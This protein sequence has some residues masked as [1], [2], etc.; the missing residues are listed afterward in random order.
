MSILAECPFCHKKQSVRNKICSCG[1]KLDRL[2]KQREKVKYWIQYYLGNKQY[3]ES[4][5]YSLEEAKDAEGKRRSQKREGRIFDIKQDTVLTFRDL[6][7]WYLELENTKSLASYR[8]I[9]IR[10]SKFNARFGNTLLNE[11]KKTDLE[12]FQTSLKREDL[13][14]SYIDNIVTQAHV[15]VK[16]AYSNDIISHDALKPFIITKRILKK[17]SN[18]RNRILTYKEFKD[19]AQDAPDHLKGIIVMGYYT[20]M[21]KGEILGLT[22]NRV[23]LEKREIRLEAIDTKTGDPRTCPIGKELLSILQALPSRLKSPYVFIYNGDPIKNIKKSLQTACERAKIPYGRKKKNG[24]TFH[25]I[26]HTFNTCARKAG[27]AEP[28]IMA[29]TGHETREM[30]DRYNKIDSQDI[31]QAMNRIE[32]FLENSV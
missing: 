4:I 28:V 32:N 21:R 5:G 18:A 27:I 23:D 14:Y 3:R 12:G 31:R 19:L 26:R 9:G 22:W 8:G 24:I 6:A 16:T 10:L 7:E 30:F 15:M 25:D 11:L 13:S 1:A 20:G 2:K 29:I 17:N